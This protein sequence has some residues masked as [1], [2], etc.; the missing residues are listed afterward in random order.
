M[1][2]ACHVKDVKFFRQF[3]HTVPVEYRPNRLRMRMRVRER[4]PLG[5]LLKN[6]FVCVSSSPQSATWVKT[7]LL[8]LVLYLVGVDCFGYV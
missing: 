5:T 7:V 4:I 3:R 2:M 1:D 6:L 8:R